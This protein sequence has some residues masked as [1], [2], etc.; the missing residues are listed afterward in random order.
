MG[1]LAML[2][3]LHLTMA[4][5]SQH[6]LDPIAF[7]HINCPRIAEDEAV[8][9]SVWRDLSLGDVDN[10]RETLS[11]LVEEGSAAPIA[12]TMTAA[13]AKMVAAGVDLAG[14]SI[15]VSEK[16]KPSDE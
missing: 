1:L 2:P 14:L 12:R 6:Q 15:H 13:T 11:L 4:L 3:D 9:I 5:L 10:A 7:A 16:A 8:L